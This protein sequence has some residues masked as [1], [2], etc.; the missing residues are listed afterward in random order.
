MSPDNN[1]K[2]FDCVN[3]YNEHQLFDLRYQL[4]KNLVDY[5]VV[6]EGMYDFNKKK[7][8]F[9]FNFKKYPKKKIRYIKV[10]T[11]PKNID[12]NKYSDFLEDYYRQRMYDGLY[13]A[14]PQDVVL[15]SCLDEI[16]HPDSIKKILRF[17]KYNRKIGICFQKMMAFNYNFKISTE[18]RWFN[19][20]PGTKF[21][22]YHSIMGIRAMTWYSQPDLRNIFN[23]I[24]YN[25]I[26]DKG[27]HFSWMGGKKNVI[28]K[29][30]AMCK[31]EERFKKEQNINVKYFKNKD[32]KNLLTENLDSKK[33]IEFISKLFESKI[34]KITPN[35]FY[36]N[37]FYKELKRAKLI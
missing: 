12:F 28:Q 20:W 16:P 11:L 34:K 19:L 15:F 17:N 5:F 37:L 9:H 3:F 32:L 30:A 4:L 27:Y 2:I 26:F 1:V 21:F 35:L 13:G 14:N 25:I 24:K 23:Y 10:E 18:S 29:Y 8:G 6:V 7:K 22:R 33:D 36:N 31:V